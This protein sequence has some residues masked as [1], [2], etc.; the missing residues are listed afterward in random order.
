VTVTS[1]VAAGGLAGVIV[2][3]ITWILSLWNINVPGDI[4]AAITVVV[5]FIV[6][7]NVPNKQSV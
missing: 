2:A 3:I 5:S 4:A 7:Y 1:K 6:G